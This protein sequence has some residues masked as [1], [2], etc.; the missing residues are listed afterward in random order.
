MKTLTNISHNK[1]QIFV[2]YLYR[3]ER[4]TDKIQEIASKQKK[5][6][7]VTEMERNTACRVVPTARNETKNTY[8]NLNSL[9]TINDHFHI[10]D[11][12]NVRAT[13]AEMVS[14]V[15][16]IAFLCY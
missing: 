9:K 2:N 7:I 8:S 12:E 3:V 13:K 5:K 6:R 1:H 10:K 16:T 15:T 4:R 11:I 14:R